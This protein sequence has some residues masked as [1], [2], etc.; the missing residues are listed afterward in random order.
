MTMLWELG[1][2]WARTSARAHGV[3]AG[4]RG[5]RM[6]QPDE[7][8][9]WL[10]ETWARRAGDAL[11]LSWSV[12]SHLAE[13]W[14]RFHSLPDSQRYA[15]CE[16]EYE[17]LLDRHFQVLAALRDDDDSDLVAIHLRCDAEGRFSAEAEFRKVAAEWALWRTFESEVDGDP[18]V[19]LQQYAFVQRLPLAREVLDPLLRRTADGVDAT[20]FTNE[21]VDW[22]YAPYDGG[23]DVI[24]P[25][26]ADRDHLREE[27]ADWLS[28]HPTGL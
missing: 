8:W 1:W 19:A 15:G 9:D 28:I 3:V 14:V 5:F 22:I 10:T 24:A 2:W 20:V 4:L 27:Y 26:L 7:S 16:D 25:T 17:I 18:D 6:P 13:R 23:A 21:A 11:P 12:R